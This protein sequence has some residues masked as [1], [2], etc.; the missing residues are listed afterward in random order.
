MKL[1]FNA[2]CLLVSR[3][4]TGIHLVG[5]TSTSCRWIDCI[6]CI[7]YTITTKCDTP[8]DDADKP[9]PTP[10]KMQSQSWVSYSRIIQV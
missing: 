2:A 6:Q 4:S 7:V 3:G 8:V 10:V 9:R 1:S 5:K